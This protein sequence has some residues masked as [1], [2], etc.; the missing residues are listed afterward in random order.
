VCREDSRRGTA[1]WRREIQPALLLLLQPGL[2]PLLI[3][4]GHRRW[5]RGTFRFGIADGPVEKRIEQRQRDGFPRGSGVESVQGTRDSDA[6]HT[7]TA[8]H[9]AQGRRRQQIARCRAS[10]IGRDGPWRRVGRGRAAH[11]PRGR[12]VCRNQRCHEAR[13][14]VI[15]A[16]IV[17]AAA[18]AA[19][20][21]VRFF[22]VHGAV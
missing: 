20:V 4:G 6:R 1:F 14:L 7:G 17:I 21:V 13:F 10:S 9:C 8:H 2:W 22:V 16:I 5:L 3:G 15:V 18:A 12:S 11:G 19:V